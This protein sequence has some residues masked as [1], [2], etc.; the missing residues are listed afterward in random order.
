M[1]KQ[2]LLDRRAAD[3]FDS[4]PRSDYNE[5]LE[6]LNF[7][8]LKFADDLATHELLFI[9]CGYATSEEWEDLVEVHGLEA[10]PDFY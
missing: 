9:A 2:I 7:N 5:R 6:Q 1:N 3:T 4:E 8:F 10:T